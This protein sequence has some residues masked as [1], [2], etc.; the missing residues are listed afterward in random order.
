MAVRMQEKAHVEVKPDESLVTDADRA[1]EDFYRER[2]AKLTPNAAVWGE[3]GGFSEPGEDGLWLIDPIDGTSNYVF[4]VP[5]WGTTAALYVDGK[6]RLGVIG[7][8]EQNEILVAV[9]GQG[10]TL[11]GEQLPMLKGGE[12]KTH[13]LVGSGSMKIFH[14]MGIYAKMRHLGSFVS[15]FA[16]FAQGKIR[17]M[18]ASHV[19]LYDAA[20]G[21][22]IARELGA[23]IIHLDGVC[24]DESQWIKPEKCQSFVFLPPGLRSGQ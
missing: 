7:L 8:P 21:I 5:N 9:D 14:A 13:Q 19:E 12:I 22:I 15:E 17:A 4:G 24:F 20:A 16:L 6:M 18:S 2:L 23:E 3:E 10:V 1:V 11:N